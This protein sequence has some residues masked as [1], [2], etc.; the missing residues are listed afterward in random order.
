MLN[1]IGP[2][3]TMQNVLML[4]GSPTQPCPEVARSYATEKKK[5]KHNSLRE[6]EI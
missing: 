2:G 1:K 5:S 3:H 4:T 6:I